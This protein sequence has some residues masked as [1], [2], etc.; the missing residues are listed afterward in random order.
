[1][2]VLHV[3]HN[4]LPLL[5]GYSI[6][7]RYILEN[8]RFHGLDVMAV[9]SGQHPNGPDDSEEIGGIAY[10][11]TRVQQTPRIPFS[12]EYRLMR[13]LEHRVSGCIRSF[14]PDVV[15]AHSPV[16]VGLPALRAARRAHIPFVYEVRDLWEN[17]SVD[18]GRFSDRSLQYRVARA[19]ETVVLTKADRVITICEQLRMELGPR[20]GS[21]NRVTVVPNAVDAQAFR[22]GGDGH[23]ARKQYGLGDGPVL[24]YAGT[25]QP[26][27]GLDLLVRA[28]RHVYSRINSARLLIVGG[29][30]SRT[31]A[32]QEGSGIEMSLHRTVAECG[33][34]GA[35]V[36]TGRVPHEQVEALYA[37]SDLVVY[38]RLLTRTTALTTPLKPLEAMAMA[39]PVLVSDVPAM[40]EL[41]EHGTTGWTFESGSEDKLAEACLHLLADDA[42]RARLAW[43]ARE[44]T[45]GNRHWPDVVAQYL[46]IYEHVT[47]LTPVGAAGEPGVLLGH[48]TLKAR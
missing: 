28:F 39:K 3:L 37:A 12:R 16:L 29:S 5:C 15:H 23:H 44:W 36:F 38:P 32:G 47:G 31:Y 8:Q 26:Y 30:A 27:E 46:A 10:H 17:A 18:R 22:P 2:R 33:L 6:R 20:T 21:M 25:F 43:A 40:L 48:A 19:L 24:L 11:R 35:V 13:A 41:V 4:S 7:S 42:L 14:K 34:D 45:V 9:T 1:M